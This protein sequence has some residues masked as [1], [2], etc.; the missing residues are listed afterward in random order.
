MRPT[1]FVSIRWWLPAAF[2][3]IAVVTALAVAQVFETQSQ[4]ALRAKAEDLA[5][6]SA[7]GA[8][9]NVSAATSLPEQLALVRDQARTR[10][11]A[12]FL[13][14]AEGRLVSDPVSLGARWVSVPNG[15][16]LVDE[17]LAGRRFVQSLDDG[18]R[19]TVALPLRRGP[20]AALV[21][22]AARPD[23]LAA[24]SIVQS[25]IWVAAAWA[26][27][28]GVLAGICVSLLITMRVRRIGAAAA[29]IA[30]GEFGSGL[31]PRFPDE[32]GHLASA[33]DTMRRKLRA[34]F[35]QLASER[36]RLRT[37]IE[38]LQEGVIA[39]RAD[40]T[41]V[42]ANARASA[43]LGEEVVEG[44]PLGNPWP[45]ADLRAL[46][47]RLFG[48]GAELQAMR[49]APAPEHT[50]A[51]TG[52]PSA[53]SGTA[54][55]VITDVTEQQRRERAEREFVANAAHELRTPV[56]A[57]ASAVEVLQLGAKEHP[58][59]RDRFLALIARQASRLGR[60]G[61]ALLT[62]A[63]AQSRAEP[64]RL[65][66]V[67]TAQLL[68]EVVTDLDLPSAALEVEDDTVAL[69][70]ADLLR[71]AV[72]NLVAN[73][74]KYA[75]SEGLAVSARGIDGDTVVVEVRDRGPGLTP[76]QAERAV[77]RFFRTGD[78]DAEGFGL[79][80]SIAREVAHALGGHLELESRSGEGTTARIVLRRAPV[81]T[82][83]N[84]GERTGREEVEVG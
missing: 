5:A 44:T 39:V 25:R 51:I 33:V 56:T 66:P 61:G 63:R 42:V 22:V 40:L 41:V 18:R 20:S 38:Q 49:V 19:V 54:V 46:A 32:L 60:L 15:R 68:E 24:S 3:L 30:E 37:L 1:W 75:S 6:G 57:I 12:L 23:L 58:E 71:Q 79:G 36:D 4:S 45:A 31:R 84:D 70:H 47:G 14:D 13:F 48:D 10:R 82:D 17:G 65:E 72:E 16:D 35:G 50:Y 62:L 52:V 81:S 55:I 53:G 7:F 9:S 74:R 26:T 78:R 11:V 77:E 29:A 8:A 73:A 69:A 67:D 80:L 28:I 83:G 21:E 59:E 64:I 27:L 43:L 76:A 2:A 34:S